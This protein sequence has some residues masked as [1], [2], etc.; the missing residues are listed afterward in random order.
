MATS[1][2]QQLQ[3]QAQ[4]AQISAPVSTPVGGAG[5]SV[6]ITA[7]SAAAADKSASI[8][9]RML[10]GFLFVVVLCVVGVIVYNK[11]CE[12][13]H[14]LNLVRLEDDEDWKDLD[15]EE[16]HDFSPD[17]RKQQQQQHRDPNF[18]LLRDIL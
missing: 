6:V 12:K 11:T 4:K 7:P 2:L 5:P 16:P 15:E 13:S 1:L 14:N 17:G 10:L 3:Q 8:S 9:L 18:T